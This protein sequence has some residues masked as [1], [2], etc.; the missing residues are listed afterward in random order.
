MNED[1]KAQ[2]EH[3]IDHPEHLRLT[4]DEKEDLIKRMKALI[5][6]ELPSVEDIRAIASAADFSLKS[7]LMKYCLPSGFVTEMRLLQWI[8]EKDLETLLFVSSMNIL[9]K[10]GKFYILTFNRFTEAREI[11]DETMEKLRIFFLKQGRPLNARFI[12]SIYSFYKP[13]SLN[14][15]VCSL[16][17]LQIYMLGAA[18]R[19]APVT[20]WLTKEIFN[21]L[22]DEDKETVLGWILNAYRQYVDVREIEQG[23]FVTDVNGDLLMIDKTDFS[24]FE[25]DSPLKAELA[26]LQKEFHER[27]LKREY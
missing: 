23:F 1:F 11:T 21:G 3:L 7:L 13:D 8:E 19:K 14:D 26:V 12:S 10:D 24:E 2:L 15:T 27:S 4:A 9:K 16:R 5:G 17:D 22:G 25:T 20:D 6:G 18:Y